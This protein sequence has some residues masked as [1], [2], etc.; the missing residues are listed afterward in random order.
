[1]KVTLEST[2]RIVEIAGV[3]GRV[4]EGHTESG[5]PVIAVITRVA[6]HQSQHTEFETEL[7]ECRAPSDAAVQA[8]PLRLIL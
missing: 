7:R 6:V 2:T 1:M 3:P 5:I 8:I 4:W